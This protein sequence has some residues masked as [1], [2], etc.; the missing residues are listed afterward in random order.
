M[1]PVAEAAQID[2]A[3]DPLGA[4]HPGERG[5]GRAF[6]RDQVSAT[7]AAAHRVDQVIRDV[8]AASGAAQALRAGHVALMQLDAPLRQP[9]SGR[10]AAVAHQ[11][12]DLLARAGESGGQATTDEARRAGH[13]HFAGHPIGC[14][15]SLRSP[16]GAGRRRGSSH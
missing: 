3:L 2:D 5:R 15:F 7:A 8:D 9:R 14:S 6:T 11:T 10:P 13:E 12:P 4:G 1:R 16:R